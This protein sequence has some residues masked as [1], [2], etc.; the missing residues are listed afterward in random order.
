MFIIQNL[1]HLAQVNKIIVPHN[2]NFEL[3]VKFVNFRAY[4]WVHHEILS[5]KPKLFIISI[6]SF[7][8]KILIEKLKDLKWSKLHNACWEPLGGCHVF[9]TIKFWTRLAAV[10]RSWQWMF[11]N[12]LT[13]VKQFSIHICSKKNFNSMTNSRSHEMK[14]EI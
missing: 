12:C 9:L 3:I 10:R 4:V 1:R 6:I 14:E 13:V 7:K 5:R 2:N 11:G 8:P